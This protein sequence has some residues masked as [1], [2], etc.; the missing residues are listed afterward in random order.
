[1]IRPLMAAL[2]VAVLAVPAVAQDANQASIAAQ[3]EGIKRLSWMF[4]VW[5]GPGSGMNRSGPYQVTQTER[6][7]TML[8][9]TII[10]I[11]GKGYSPDGSVGFN[12]FAVLS[13]DPATK[14]YKL[15]SHALGY[16][17]DF[18]LVPTDNGYVW[19]VPAGPGATIRYTATLSGG[20]WN[21]TGDYVAGSA[22]PRRI[23][24]MN[25][26]RVGDTDWPNGGGIAKD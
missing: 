1:M 25:L 20:V 18:A 8:D 2:A 17:G 11:E 14:S 7:G 9:G 19:E 3:K 23:F 22:P 12:A 6:I 5:R 21:E 4:G 15:S 26:K 16:S 13:Y 24:E 10:V